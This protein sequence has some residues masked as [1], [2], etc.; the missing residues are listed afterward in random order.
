M[1]FTPLRVSPEAA[2]DLIQNPSTWN[3]TPLYRHECSFAPEI[4][5]AVML[6]L[7]RHP[8]INSNHLFRADISFDEPYDPSSVAAASAGRV[9][10]LIEFQGFKTTRVIRRVLIPRNMLVDKALEQTCLFS[11]QI[12]PQNTRSVVTYLPHI[13][14]AAEAPFYHPAVFG[15]AFVH[16]S[17]SAGSHGNISISYAFFDAQPRIEKLERTALHLLAVLHKHGHGTAAGYVKRVQHDV[18]LSQ[19]IVQNTYARLKAKYAKILIQNWA[20][21][22]DPAKHVFEDLGIAAFLIELWKE[23]YARDAFPGFVDIG[24]GNGLLVHILSNEGYSGWGFDARR[25]KSWD[26]YD[27]KNAGRLREMVLIPSILRPTTLACITSSPDSRETLVNNDAHGNLASSLQTPDAGSSAPVMESPVTTH[28]GL[29]PSSPFIISNHADE[30]TPWTALL[31]TASRCHFMMIPCCS[32]NLTGARFRAPQLKSARA[33]Q[34]AYSTLV[35]WL[36]HIAT[37]CG[38]QVEKEM[39]RI[40]STR[41]TAL[42]G[43]RRSRPFEE[44]NLQQVLESYGGGHGWEENSRKLLRGAVRGH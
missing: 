4:F 43:R 40:P 34:S 23:I 35:T 8:N 37:D 18:L 39:L 16:D 20:E 28:D 17:G 19:P 2:P 41:N 7:I 42:I 6:N 12:G 11:E 32:H 15:I 33:P 21:S 14:S 1:G 5:K 22:T 13:T 3:W 31:A 36:S 38:W 24:C 27:E 30:L 29:F 44:I 25:R 26:T 9:G 10:G